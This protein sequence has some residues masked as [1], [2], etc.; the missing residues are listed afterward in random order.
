MRNA[1]LLSFLILFTSPSRAQTAG[2]M[3]SE[4]HA[5]EEWVELV[6]AGTEAIDTGAYFLCQ[7]PTYASIQ[8]LNMVAGNRLLAPGEYLAVSFSALAPASG[9]VGLY[10]P[11]TSDFGDADSM[12]DYMEYGSG[13]HTRE[14][15]AVS[16]GFWESGA[17]VTTPASGQSMARAS[18]NVFG[19]DNWEAAEPSPG[20][21]NGIVTSVDDNGA[22]PSGVTISPVYPNPVRDAA[23]FDVHLARTE[24]MRIT[25]HDI[26]G[27][28]V[29]KIYSGSIS[30]DESFRVDMKGLAGGMY[31]IRVEGETFSRVL[32]LVRLN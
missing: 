30:A 27:R 6:N 1:I 4:V 5:E 29:S 25:L 11:G 31:W 24:Q 7:F 14:P 9:E 3:I 18:F 12:I 17:F 15:L 2:L 23:S 16:N 20:A 21:P 13:N 8:G 19:P 10:V 22:L 26:L 28:E 32:P